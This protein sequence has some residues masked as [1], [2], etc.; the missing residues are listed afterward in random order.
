MSIFIDF[1]QNKIDYMS[2]VFLDCTILYFWGILNLN[3]F[4]LKLITA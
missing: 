1:R 3:S 2:V 4:Y